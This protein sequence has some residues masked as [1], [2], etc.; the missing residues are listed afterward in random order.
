MTQ[1]AMTN[2]NNLLDNLLTLPI[3]GASVAYPTY[4]QKLEFLSD[5]SQELIPVLGLVFL[6]V[7]LIAFV[8][9]RDGG[10]PQK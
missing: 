5:I 9:N 8:R 6:I 3:A 1:K 7:R 10:K 4:K 2:K